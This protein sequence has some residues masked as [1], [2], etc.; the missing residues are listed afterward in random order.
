MRQEIEHP[1]ARRREQPRWAYVRVEPMAERP[2]AGRR[3]LSARQRYRWKVALHEAGHLVVACITSKRYFAGAQI[4]F[5]ECA[6]CAYL[7]E[8]DDDF[9]S[10]A[11]VAA[12]R[13]A[14]A[15]AE[16]HDPPWVPMYRGKPLP[17][18]RTRA[19]RKALTSDRRTSMPDPVFLAR[20]AIAHVEDEPLRWAQRLRWI[21]R[22][23]EH[24]VGE[25]AAAVLALA[26]ILY[27]Q[28]IVLSGDVARVLGRTE[29]S[30]E[31]K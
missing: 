24:Y 16:Q 4:L 2:Q 27:V 11:A 18:F 20:W 30:K 13:A 5:N 1:Q 17:E 14:E 21:Y 23:A 29:E 12:G 22:V 19:V 3:K 28:G 26:R 9:L 25:H 7:P 15:L 31:V 8:Q 6:P 10:A